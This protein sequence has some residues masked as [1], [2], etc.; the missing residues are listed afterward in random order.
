MLW[1]L[2]NV[3]F[4]RNRFIDKLGIISKKYRRFS[5]KHLMVLSALGF[6]ILY[7]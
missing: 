5:L 1:V 6:E 7:I 2:L 4:F 3:V